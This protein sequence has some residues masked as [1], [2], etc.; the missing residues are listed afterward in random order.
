MFSYPRIRLFLLGLLMTFIGLTSSQEATAQ[1]AASRMNKL[2]SSLG[3]DILP[4]LESHCYECHNQDL[5]E[6][7]IDLSQLRSIEALRRSTRTLIRVRD[8]LESGQMP[9]KDSPQLSDAEHRRVTAWVRNFLLLEAEKQ[10]G[11]PGPVLL[12]RLNNAEYTY[13]IRDLTGV[14]S[15]SP[16]QQFP[17]DGAAGEGFTNTGESLVISPSL[18]SK[19]LDAAKEISKH[20]V[21]E[22]NGIRFSEFTTRRDWT[23]EN[24]AA[25]QSFYN[26]FS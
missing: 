24:L 26:R 15:L 12:R 10:A 20:L 17:V 4:L 23:D 5:A 2:A 6:A 25:I 18:V 21:L 22:P 3:P 14:N 1:S 19:Y 11:D 8:I 13:T 9:P 7:D 16:A